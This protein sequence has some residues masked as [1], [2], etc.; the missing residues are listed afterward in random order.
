VTLHAGGM[1]DEHADLIGC[2][3]HLERIVER[4]EAERVRE[5]SAPQAWCKA[6]VAHRNAI[7]QPSSSSCA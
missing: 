1:Q 6:C 3:A 2:K 7:V 5:S 4:A